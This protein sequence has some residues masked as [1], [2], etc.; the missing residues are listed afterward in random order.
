MRPDFSAARVGDESAYFF[1][2]NRGKESIVL[3]LKS[4]DGRDVLTRLLYGARNSIAVA[5]L[6]T[7]LSF[8][9][10]MMLGLLAATRRVTRGIEAILRH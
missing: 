3:D 7:I 4:D 10:G 2:F 9:V 6:T 8:A 1:A 5:L